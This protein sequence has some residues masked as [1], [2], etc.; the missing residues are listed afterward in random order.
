[1]RIFW[2]NQRITCILLTGSD[3]ARCQYQDVCWYETEMPKRINTDK[4]T[5]AVVL[6]CYGI[7]FPF[8]VWVSEIMLQQTQVAT[9]I[10]YYNKWMKVELIRGVCSLLCSPS[11]LFRLCELLSLCRSA[12]PRCRTSQLLLWRWLSR[13]RWR[14]LED[15]KWFDQCSSYTGREPDVGRAWLLF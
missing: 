4:Y 7:F 14:L 13:S 15:K 11:A 2:S 8:L 3:R 10:D 1:M 12:G 6:T 9:V 5:A